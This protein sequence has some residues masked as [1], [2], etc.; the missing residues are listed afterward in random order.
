M[1]ALC[2]VLVAAALLGTGCDEDAVTADRDVAVKSIDAPGGDLSHG[3]VVTPAATVENKGES[4]ASLDAW[5]SLAGPTDAVVYTDSVMGE[6]LDAGALRQLTFGTSDPLEAAGKWTARCSLWSEADQDS[7]NNVLSREFEV[8]APKDAVELIPL[9]NEIGGWSRNG[10][11]DIAENETKLYELIDGEG[12]PFIEN[13]FVKFVRQYFSGQVEGRD[14]D[15][16]LRVVD[17]ADS[18]NADAVYDAVATGNETP[19]TQ[20]HAG[21]EARIEQ[22]LFAYEVDFWD[23]KFYVWVTISDP[24]EPALNIA[25]MFAHNV[26]AAIHN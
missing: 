4:A 1:R 18:G 10:A 13:G 9:D 19:W 20:D 17:M 14:V 25:K 2:V 7:A 16:E 15:M 5:M 12:T 21:V 26:S 22:S 3:A 11:M 6:T 8:G 23:D 24:T